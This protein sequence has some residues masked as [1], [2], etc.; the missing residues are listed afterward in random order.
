MVFTK[1]LGYVSRMIDCRPEA[2][3]LDRDGVVNFDSPQYILSPDAWRPIPGSLEAIARLTRAQ[4]PVAIVSNQSAIGR[5]MID[6]TTFWAIHAK[7]IESIEAAEGTLAYTA[8]CPHAPE[9]GCS[10]RK[11]EPGL[12]LATLERLGLGARSH[13]TILIGDSV[14][15]VQAAVAAGVTPVLVDSGYGDA[16]AKFSAARALHPSL[17]HFPDLAAVV[18]ALLSPERC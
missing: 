8:Y 15:D 1:N 11:P 2:V 17:Q 7:M 3:L 9:A 18:D 13:H 10:C 4:I 6:Q 16:A 12:L 14:R 5:G